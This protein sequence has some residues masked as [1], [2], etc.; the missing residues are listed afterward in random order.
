MI[1][2]VH[3]LFYSNLI[4]VLVTWVAI[5]IFRRN[6]KTQRA[7]ELYLAALSPVIWPVV[8]ILLIL[9]LIRKPKTPPTPN[10]Q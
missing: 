9:D 1:I 2:P 8:L 5:F 10:A 7:G 6:G 3:Y 4:G